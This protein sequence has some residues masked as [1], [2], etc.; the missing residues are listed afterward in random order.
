MTPRLPVALLSAALVWSHPG[1]AA[2]CFDIG[3]PCDGVEAWS[4]VQPLVTGTGVPTD[5]I[6]LL[7]FFGPATGEPSVAQVAVQVTLEGAPVPGALAD[8]GVPRVLGWRPAAPLVP[9]GHYTVEGTINNPDG[10]PGLPECGE[11]L[12]EFALEFTAAPVAMPPLAP[13]TVAVERALDIAGALQLDNFVCCDGAYPYEA[14]GG[15]GGVEI[16]WDPGHC[17]YLQWTTS[18]RVDHGAVFDNP[19]GAT[20]MLAVELRVDGV[21]DASA[22]A[23]DGTALLVARAAAPICTELVVRNF[24]TGETLSTPQQCHG[25]DDLDQLGPHDL[26]P[27][28]PELADHCQGPAYRCEVD[29][30]LGMWDPDRCEPWPS[31]G[32]TTGEPTTGD[33]PTTGAPATSTASTG[34]TDGTSAGPGADGLVDHGCSCASAPASPLAA[35]TVLLLLA[36]APRR[37]RAR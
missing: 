15:C 14:Y 10:V 37:R 34:G 22:L 11:P 36:C 33:D 7:Q 13:P 9:G 28:S 12:V 1:E 21:P 25:Q 26:T 5:G 6:L 4:A 20:M 24:V 16:L 31:G 23:L 35:L 32:G 29:E 19:G 30:S 3:N 18:Q 17:T 8:I 2:S 27:T